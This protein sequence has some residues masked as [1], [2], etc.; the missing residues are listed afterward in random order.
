MSEQLK[1]PFEGQEELLIK[2]SGFDPN[3]IIFSFNEPPEEI[4]RVNKE[5]FF[6]KGKL[7]Q[8]DHEIYKIFKSFLDKANSLADPKPNSIEGYQ[9]TIEL[10]KRALEFY[11]L[12]ENYVVNHPLN[13]EL[14]SY[15][16]MDGGTQARFM[17]DKIEEID[18][19]NK[20]ME[21]DYNVEIDALQNL[22][23][24]E[25]LNTFY[26]QNEN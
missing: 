3:S 7:I 11:A 16:E 23:D 15:V 19:L 25:L 18:E 5:G 9:N 8:N 2:G 20:K 4:I 21:K 14:F 13:N 22:S 12:K 24:D 10:L 26:N 17:L 6:W 1:I